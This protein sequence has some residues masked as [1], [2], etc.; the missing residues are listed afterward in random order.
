MP[1]ERSAVYAYPRRRRREQNAV[2]LSKLI[3]APPA[4]LIIAANSLYTTLT[5][6]RDL[7]TAALHALE[8]AS[9]CLLRILMLFPAGRLYQ[10]YHAFAWHY[11]SEG[12]VEALTQGTTINFGVLKSSIADE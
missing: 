5:E 2:C 12:E 8:L 3:P 4:S 11:P 7:D 1:P 6:R 9:G 10:G